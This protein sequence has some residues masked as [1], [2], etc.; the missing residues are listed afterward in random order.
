MKA[1]VFSPALYNLAEATR[2]LEIARACRD[3]FD[4]L[5]VS[6]G[7]QFEH[8]VEEAGYPIRRLEPQVTPAKI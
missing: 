6:Y 7:G 1:L 8:L 4:I 5:F 2:A 3:L